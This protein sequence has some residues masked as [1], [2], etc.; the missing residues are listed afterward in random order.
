MTIDISF[1]A[2]A[3]LGGVVGAIGAWVGTFIVFSIGDRLD[4]RGKLW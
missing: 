4:R 3:F 1:V 2:S